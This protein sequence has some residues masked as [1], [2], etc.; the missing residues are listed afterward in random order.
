LAHV[1][2]MARRVADARYARPLSNV[3]DQ[4]RQAKGA[5]VWPAAVI[6]VDVL[7]NQRHLGDASISQT[8]DLV[9]DLFD[10]PRRFAP[11]RI[12]D[13]AE[14][15]ELVAAF[16][17]SDESG[18]AARPRC[19]GSRRREVIEFVLGREFRL[20]DNLAAL[21]PRDEIGQ[22]VDALWPDHDVHGR[23]AANDLF[24]LGLRNAAGHGDHQ[25]APFFF[26]R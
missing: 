22:A 4:F 5:A 15:T 17:H 3:G 23:S 2:W 19:R 20:D 26:G 10:W 21:C 7:A 1:A 16:L 24:T 9:D 14:G 12:R 18:D 11:A 6:G 13:D 8:I 25:A